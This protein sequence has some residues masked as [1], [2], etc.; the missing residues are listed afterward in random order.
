MSR[1]I[2]F[3]IGIISLTSCEPYC[4]RCGYYD[5]C[6]CITYK[7]N[8]GGDYFYAEKLLGTWQ[9]SHNT[10]VGT[11][12]IKEIDFINQY[13]CDIV[14]SIANETTYYTKTYSYAYDGNYI[15]FTDGFDTFIFHIDGYLFPELYLRSSYDKY[16]WRKVKSHG[17]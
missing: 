16:T 15:K 13:K 3:L 5:H 2:I 8:H 12:N 17:C 10:I 6:I 9:C 11:M 7:P 1:I 14:Y 4:P